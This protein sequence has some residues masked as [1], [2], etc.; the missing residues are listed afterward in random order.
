MSKRFFSKSALALLFILL[1]TAPLCADNG[2]KQKLRVKG[3]VVITSSRLSA[4]N[5]SNTAIFEGSVVAKSEDMTLY[6]DRM[7]VFYSEGGEINRIV[8]YGNVKLIKENGVLTSEEAVY[9]AEEKK[10]VFTGNPR[11]IEG[12]NVITGSRMIYLIEEDRSIIE[13]S[14]AYLEEKASGGKIK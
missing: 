6:S 10:L 8:A 11:A 7:K 12:S 13:D 9:L 4:D 1:A 14:K 3:P 5:N 2:E